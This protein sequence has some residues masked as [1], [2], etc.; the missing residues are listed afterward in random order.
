MHYHLKI[1]NFESPIAFKGEFYQCRNDTQIFGSH[2]LKRLSNSRKV[3]RRLE[4]AKRDGKLIVKSKR[5]FVST[6]TQII[7]S[8]L[9][10]GSLTLSTLSLTY[11]FTDK[12]RNLKNEKKRKNSKM[13]L[14]PSRFPAFF[15]SD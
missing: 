8:I 1:E 5:H 15:R 6:R 3:A 9:T 13:N 2:S 10:R 14:I 7:H 4:K 11:I 12:T